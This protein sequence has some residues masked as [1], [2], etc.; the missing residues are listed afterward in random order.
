M[1]PETT[2]RERDTQAPE[3]DTQARERDAL[4]RHE[5]QTRFDAPLLLEAG[6]G[7]GKT[8]VLVARVLAF[9]LGPGWERAQMRL[10]ETAV[11][12]PTPDDIAADVLRRIVAITFT[13][14]AAAEM[15]D[16]VAEHLVEV[17]SGDVPVGL[18]PEA[19]PEPESRAARARTLLG[20][21][22]QL[23]ALTF[24]AYCRRLL[25]DHP[26]EAG[27]HPE[28][29]VDPDGQQRAEVVREVLEAHLPEVFA[30]PPDADYA[31]LLR[32]G[33]GPGMLEEAACQL[34]G[35]GIE[36]RD[37]ARDPFDAEAVA[38]LS[39]RA[40]EAL[41]A[42]RD[43]DGG[44]LAGVARARRV[45]AAAQEVAELADACDAEVPGDL[46]ALLA[47]RDG[48]SESGLESLRKFAKGDFGKL[49][50]AA[51]G[52]DAGLVAERAVELHRVL[53]HLGRLD[54]P[55]LR[56]SARVL[57]RLLDEAGTRLRALG[58]AS[59][60]GLLRGARDLLVHR[61][62]VARFERARIDLLL[63]DEFQDTDQLQCDLLDALAFVPD[64]EPAPA[65]FLVG[66]PK[67][68]IYGWRS[69]DL[70]AYAAFRDR[71]VAAGGRVLPLVVNFRSVPAVL[72]EVARV[73]APVMQPEP[74]LQPPFEP[75]LACDRLEGEPGFEGEG[76]AAVEHWLSVRAADDGSGLAAG[77]NREATEAEA[78]AVARDIA[79]LRER[80]VPLTE[81]ALLLRSTSD[82][83]IYLGA[84]RA[85]GLPF[86]VERETLHYQ[87][88]EI[89][90][91]ASLVR[92]VLD[93]HDQVALVATLRASF[94]GVPDAALQPLWEAGLPGAVAEIDGAAPEP[95]E[96]A[97]AALARGVAAMPKGVPGLA[98]VAGFEGV[99]ARFL[100]ALHA[101]RR[102]AR[103]APP[104]RFVEALRAALPLEAME[105]GRY[106]G[107]HRV[108]SLERFLRELV[109][110]LEEHGGSAAAVAARLRRDG[111]LEREIHEGRPR[112]LVDDAV[113]VM[114]V[115][116][117]KGLDFGHVYL[118][119]THKGT[120][121]RRVGE[122]RV[123]WHDG[124]P[125]LELFGNPS[126]GLVD[127]HEARDAREVCERIRLLYVALTR[128]KVRLVV[129]GKRVPSVAP[130]A[131]ALAAT[132][133]ELLAHRE[134]TEVS[135]EAR[136][137]AGSKAEGR[138]GASGGGGFFVRDTQGVL[139]RLLGEASGP[140]QPAS[141]AQAER[142]GAERVA[143]DAAR[144]RALR[145]AARA[146]EAQPFGRAAS[147]QETAKEAASLRAESDERH[148]GEADRGVAMRSG[149][150]VH[151][152]LEEVAPSA[153][154]EAF[155][156]ALVRILGPAPEAAVAERAHEVLE[157][158]L[159]GPLR[160][161]LRA[162][163]AG[164][165]IVA[166][167]LP[168]LLA[169]GELPS[170]GSG[171][172]AASKGPAGPA[173]YWV[174]AI[175]LLYRDPESED[176]V[177]VDYKTDRLGE[178]QLAERALAY[179]GQG[180]VYARAVQKAFGL[181]EPPH[182]ELWFLHTGDIARLPEGVG[183]GG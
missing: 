38:R 99:A 135:L 106:L 125:E 173:G 64:G 4:A 33:V 58:V 66:D 178:G 69:A 93:R 124:R 21:L 165:A 116:K 160:D 172:T 50:G 154:P 74:G 121:G 147:D 171:G 63:V 117:A 100:D 62:E 57:A 145:S 86:V 49:A 158:F 149:T 96:R 31:T 72:D 174:G 143:A 95:L 112:A 142:V 76:H 175:D 71:L 39:R 53:R 120:G 118:L 16:R 134:A 9:A 114:T 92:C 180:A 79:A 24:H 115:H 90:D 84:L 55:V 25:R 42:F 105:S 60:G 167:E 129:A 56:A 47:L 150:A 18:E 110:A 87:R 44:R 1:S 131:L 10:S 85:E 40:A 27:L 109:P 34:L 82:F 119:Q 8:A 163:D 157:R 101:L 28:L 61:P 7:T 45:A 177:V 26:L 37:L 83:Q 23:R 67:Q 30:D 148:D 51:L 68:S 12:P 108:A 168:V 70:A 123:S 144:L 113:H 130:R 77:S 128:A 153:G 14:A 122:T 73:V 176:W 6:A 65:L 181:P 41:R 170:P 126:A 17:A 164:Q 141:R 182:F 15:A 137:L 94:V 111:S 159:A 89:V 88:R 29:E 3:R 152:V 107:A 52:E 22:D 48:V 136:L 59:F 20:G 102:A 183:A 146:R 13:E 162:L 11:T 97:Q 32:A 46:E 36:A 169:P 2:S 80:G 179:A 127:A 5:A 35:E 43:A 133:A 75:L 104:E 155:E 138:A 166:R 54:P 151:A 161:R 98:D 19:L 139:W 156:E 140:A 91:A 103:E 132:H 78:V 81:V